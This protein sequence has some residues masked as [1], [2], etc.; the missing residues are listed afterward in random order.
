MTVSEEIRNTASSNLYLE[1]FE[2]SPD[3]SEESFYQ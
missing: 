2:I 1:C 3:C